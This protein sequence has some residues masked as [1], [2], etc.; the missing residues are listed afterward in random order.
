MVR[1]HVP[2][3]QKPVPTPLNFDALVSENHPARILW[4]LLGTLDLSR[5]EDGVTSVEGH[6]GRALLSP[7]M[8]RKRPGLA[9]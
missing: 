9:V 8:M 6:A 4:T 5:F 1:L 7:R 3:R 2:D